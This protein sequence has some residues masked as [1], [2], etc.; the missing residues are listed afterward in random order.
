M[1]CA[2]AVGAPA[3]VYKFNVM[4]LPKRL[5]H[6]VRLHFLLLEQWCAAIGVRGDGLY[7]AGRRERRDPFVYG[8]RT[9]DG[10]RGRTDRNKSHPSECHRQG[11]HLSKQPGEIYARRLCP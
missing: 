9:G 8:A 6:L 7:H 4:L 10:A 2:A 1:S 3:G 5:S 11:W